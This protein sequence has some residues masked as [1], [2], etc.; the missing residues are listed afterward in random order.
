MRGKDFVVTNRLYE[1]ATELDADAFEW[2][3]S[4]GQSIDGRVYLW[5]IGFNMAIEQ[6]QK[7]GLI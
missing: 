6:L 5:A 4:I 3:S 1:I 7:G 2:I